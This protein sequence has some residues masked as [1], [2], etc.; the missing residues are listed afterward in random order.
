MAIRTR[1]VWSLTCITPLTFDDRYAVS[2]AR[3]Y[4]VTGNDTYIKVAEELYNWMWNLGWDKNTSSCSGGFWFGTGY[5]KK[6]TV[7]NGQSLILAAKLYRY[8]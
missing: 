2:Y 8:T 7:T 5:G 6:I 1:I 3:I 4:E